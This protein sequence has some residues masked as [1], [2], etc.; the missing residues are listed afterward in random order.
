MTEFLRGGG[1]EGGRACGREEGRASGREGG[2]EG[3]RR[4]VRDARCGRM[5]QEQGGVGDEGMDG[6][7]GGGTWASCGLV[8]RDVIELG[9]S[10]RERALPTAGGKDTDQCTAPKTW[11][12][13]PAS[14]PLHGVADSQ[15]NAARAQPWR[16]AGAEGSTQL[17]SCPQVPSV[18]LLKAAQALSCFVPPPFASLDTPL[19]GLPPSPLAD[20]S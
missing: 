9:S 12:H 7:G 17:P 1:R 10:V 2:R 6:R 4:E 13:H 19:L 5:W 20:T 8:T 3:E 16:P 11:M 18:S 14:P 15:E